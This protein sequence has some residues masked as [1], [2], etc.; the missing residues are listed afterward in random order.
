MGLWWQKTVVSGQP[1]NSG[2]SSRGGM[3]EMTPT[4]PPWH[5]PFL[6]GVSQGRMVLVKPGQDQALP[7]SK[8]RLDSPSPVHSEA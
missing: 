4:G 6:Q 2:T 3:A 5:T 8:A 1:G 7:Q